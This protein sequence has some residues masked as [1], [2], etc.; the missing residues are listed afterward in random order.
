MGALDCGD[1]PA[2]ADTR[3]R[4]RKSVRAGRAGHGGIVP[5]WRGAGGAANDARRGAT[6]VRCADG[7]ELPGV[8][9]ITHAGDR[10]VA[11]RDRRLALRTQDLGA[12][13]EVAVGNRAAAVPAL[14][15]GDGVGVAG[16]RV[17]EAPAAR[18][19]SDR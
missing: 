14:A 1:F 10:P 11:G 13:D 2:P 4:A 9:W 17:L 15:C 18:A 3:T 12:A 5:D 6:R 19:R 7:G 16:A 8:E